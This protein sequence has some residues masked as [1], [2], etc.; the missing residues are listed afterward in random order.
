[1]GFV[2]HQKMSTTKLIICLIT[3]SLLPKTTLSVTV[4]D[5]SSS[6]SSTTEATSTTSQ[7]TEVN[8]TFSVSTSESKSSDD[9]DKDESKNPQKLEIIKQIRK[10]NADGSYT[11]GYEAEDGT[12]KIES[13][14]V[15]GNVKGTYGYID[16]NGEIKRVSYTA[17]NAT[18]LKTVSEDTETEETA[19]LPKYN[20]RTSAS[21]TRRPNLST[22]KSSV[23][24]SIPRRRFHFER[25]HGPN[26]VGQEVNSLN[27]AEPTTTV[28]YATSIS[29]TAK[30]VLLV[31]PTQVPY[32]VKQSASVEQISRPEKLEMNSV[33][34]VSTNVKNTKKKE[35]E[36]GSNK[37]RNHLR[38]QLSSENT[39]NFETQQQIIYG[40]S[41]GD[42]NTHIYGGGPSASVSVRPLY[43]PTATPRVPVQVLAA[44]Q[45][46]AQLQ[47]TIGKSP[48]TTTERVYVK[49]PK[50]LDEKQRYE[51]STEPQTAGPVVEI[52]PGRDLN[53]G[54]EDE[55]R[56]FRERPTYRPREYVRYV[57]TTVLPVEQR[58]GY[59]NPVGVPP[60]PLQAYRP[61]E[62]QQQ[63]LRET[64]RV[65]VRRPS[66]DGY[67]EQ[68]Q[69]P[70]Y[71]EQGGRPAAAGYPGDYQHPY[72]PPYGFNNPYR[73]GGSPF[74]YPDRPLTTRDF[75]R[76][77]QLLI[78]RHTQLQRYG[79]GGIGGYGGHPYYPS[80]SPYPP[81]APYYGYQIPRP[82]YYQNNPLYDPRYE[83]P[84][85]SPS[86]PSRQYP[87]PPA[88]GPS[89]EA[90]SENEQSLNQ[91]NPQYY[92]SQRTIPR[93]RQF[94]PPPPAPSRQYSSSTQV[95]FH[96]ADYATNTNQLGPNLPDYLPPHVREDLL[97]RMFMLALRTDPNYA[98]A[99]AASQPEPAG[100]VPHASSIEPTTIAPVTSRKPVR[101]VQILGE[102]EP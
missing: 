89:S 20:N 56:Q 48:S 53:E 98:H 76:L 97:Y 59:R 94:L 92:D 81:S 37:T 62:Q 91:V 8:T 9:L 73:G 18:G 35:E 96:D 74:D 54:A 50:R 22:T 63:Y 32:G 44:R 11:I 17:N 88:S 71:R 55:R 1:M 38:R 23:V 3:I 60:I 66:S 83:N 99:A 72:P 30:P 26:K 51:Q 14:D 40:Q 43:N 39:E 6:T 13:R 34:K 47:N 33:S 29:S 64:T 79:G 65:P 70:E 7:K 90:P 75:E 42:D 5:V 28:V 77:L 101:S 102:E 41:S 57:P 85:Y 86:T 12:F 2:S 87:A 93:R 4:P 49:S 45:R 84:N 19:Q 31:R 80:A 10:I 67:Q 21:T 95:P 46:A 52:P 15:L 69:S 61:E 58:H 82:P 24:Q 68:A 25:I 36:E 27:A 100:T 78:Y 16:E